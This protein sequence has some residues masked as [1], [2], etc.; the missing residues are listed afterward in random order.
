MCI[1]HMKNKIYE[2]LLMW[3]EIIYYLFNDVSNLNSTKIALQMSFTVSEEYYSF[4]KPI[5][6]QQTL[7]ASSK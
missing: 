1:V 2:K 5:R 7:T 4:F 6:L 3:L